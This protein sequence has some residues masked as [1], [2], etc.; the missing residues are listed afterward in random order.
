MLSFGQKKQPLIGVDISS[1]SVK[2]LELSRSGNGYRVES[3]SVEPLPTNAVVEKN[4][5][6]VDA[7][8]N[9]LR[10]ALKRASS[11]AKLAAVAVP[12]SAAISKLITMPANLSEDELE[13]QI[14]L[15][16][17]QY[18]PYALEEVNLD[19][20]VLGQTEENSETM[21]VLLAASRTENVE[22]RTNA[23]E[24]GGLGAKVVDIE[25]YAMEGACRLLGDIDP[26]TIV[27]VID[28]G[29]TMTSINVMHMNHLIYT[30]EQA[31]GGRQLTEPRR[32][33][34]QLAHDQHA[35]AVADVVERHRQRTHLVVA[36]L[37]LIGRRSHCWKFS[38]VH[39][40]FSRKIVLSCCAAVC[41]PRRLPVIDEEGNHGC[42][43]GDEPDQRGAR[44]AV[45][46]AH[47]RSPRAADAVHGLD[48]ARLDRTHVRRRT[49]DRRRPPG[50]G[51]ARGGARLPRRGPGQRL[52]RHEGAPRR[53]GDT[54][55]TRRDPSDAVR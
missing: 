35:P 24:L 53:G 39:L 46:G 21:D 48:R 42:N 38:T 51:A 17:D 6:D 43:D 54:G 30:R 52:E 13:S 47:A 32:A 9:T 15:E 28:I 2:V 31:F 10:K 16:A 50:T 36:L 41:H 55:G 45:R 29:A 26:D 37:G 20:E 25:S 4:I 44:A 23:I 11:K 22:I 33:A 19:F 49:R 5:S 1:T 40:T 12:A 8:G 3:Y 14:Q 27:A 18:I 7:V 34:E